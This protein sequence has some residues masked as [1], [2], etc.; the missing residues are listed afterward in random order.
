M[1][2]LSVLTDD[3]PRS[4]GGYMRAQTS[5]NQTDY[6]FPLAIY[7]RISAA[8]LD[9]SVRSRAGAWLCG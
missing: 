7:D 1:A 6:R 5:T 2:L 3:G 9:V 8:N 4:A